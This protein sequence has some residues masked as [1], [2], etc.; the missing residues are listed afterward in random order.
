MFLDIG[1][2]L[3][4]FAC[5]HV[6]FCDSVAIRLW[7]IEEGSACGRIPYDLTNSEVRPCQ[8]SCRD[9]LRIF[10]WLSWPIVDR[11]SLLLDGFTR[12]LFFQF[13]S[14]FAKKDDC[15]FTKFKNKK[16]QIRMRNDNIKRDIS[17]TKKIFSEN[18]KI[19]Q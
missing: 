11:V 15:D 1:N 5:K 8:K 18:K 4:V 19:H 6:F 9:G 17:K 13:P 14:G 3:A 2:I 10:D 12:C 7:Y 16:L